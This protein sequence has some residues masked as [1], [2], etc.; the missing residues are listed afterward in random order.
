MHQF[1]SILRV[2]AIIISGT[3]ACVSAQ[4]VAPTQITEQLDQVTTLANTITSPASAENEQQD[5]ASPTQPDLSTSRDP[6][7]QEAG[8]ESQNSQQPPEPIP[9]TS[10]AK[11]QWDIEKGSISIILVGVLLVLVLA[12][13]FIPYWVLNYLSTTRGE[14]AFANTTEMMAYTLSLSCL[15][16]G[17]GAFQS[18]PSLIFK[19]LS[20]ASA[21]FGSIV[22]VSLFGYQRQLSSNIIFTVFMFFIKVA[23]FCFTLIFSILFSIVAFFLLR[24]SYDEAKKKE[25]VKAGLLLGGAAASWKASNSLLDGLSKYA[26]GENI[27]EIALNFPNESFFGLIKQGFQGY[28]ARFAYQKRWNP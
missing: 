27:P 21:V 25:Y 15:F 14:I 16:I 11:S 20:I 7:S 6:K 1:T 8:N 5:K 26:N 10:P 28:G 19:G 22:L 9:D 13:P 17:V 24:E 23:Y 4:P 12:I 18:T 3:L 2:W